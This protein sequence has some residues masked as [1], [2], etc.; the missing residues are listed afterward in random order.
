MS[1]DGERW[2]ERGGFIVC[3]LST[4]FTGTKAELRGLTMS[5]WKDNLQRQRKNH[6][7]RRLAAVNR[8]TDLDGDRRGLTL[9]QTAAEKCSIDTPVSR[10][11]EKL[12]LIDI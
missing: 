5:T 11:R 6:S 9:R 2:N 3:C 1:F 12:R 4:A 7:G 8:E 10:V